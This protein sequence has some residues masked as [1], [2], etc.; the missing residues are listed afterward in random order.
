MSLFGF[1]VVEQFAARRRQE[2]R[3]QLNRQEETVVVQ[4]TLIG[5]MY[6]RYP[7]ESWDD[8]QLEHAEEVAREQTRLQRAYERPRRFLLRFFSLL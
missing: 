2:L 4:S 7:H 6:H 8:I 1:F 5:V 3:A